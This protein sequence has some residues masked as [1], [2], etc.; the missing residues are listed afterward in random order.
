M[1][2]KLVEA[3]MNVARLNFSH[4]SHA[5]HAAV[6]R[7]VRSVSEE[8]GQPVAVMQ[9][10][11]GP[12]I[13]VG[14]FADGR[15][16]LQ[17]G[18][19]FTFTTQKVLGDATRVS[20]S[21]AG[22][23][24]DVS[25]GDRFLVD[26]GDLVFEVEST[27]ET[28]V[29]CKVI[30]GGELKNRRGLNA[31]G[32]DLQ[33]DG[34]TQ[35]DRAD[36]DFGVKHRVDMVAMSFVSRA[37]DVQKLKQLLHQL[38]ATDMPVVAK[39]ERRLAL[40]N[41]DGI[42][43]EVYAVMVARGDLALEI[44]MREIPVAQKHIIRVCRQAG[45]PVITATQMLESMIHNPEPT[46]AEATD[47]ANAV[48]DG[49]DALML[50]G[51]TAIGRYPEE[52]VRTM[53]EIAERAEHAV[54]RGEVPDWEPLQP[55]PGDIDDTIAA[56]AARAAQ[57]LATQAILAVTRSGSTALRLARQ[58]V[59]SPIVAVTPDAVVARRLLLAWGVHPVICQQAKTR[60]EQV[61]LAMRAAQSAGLVRQGDT[62]VLAAGL[63]GEAPG[64]TNLLEICR[65]E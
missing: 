51:E 21:Y 20:V 13:R 3:G 16:T 36:L 59:W 4:G 6:I 23:P 48:F 45:K 63:P 22:L 31:P 35:K 33:I 57:N 55:E 12:R 14:E 39:I 26:D 25:P 38:K 46:R 49:S 10:L 65:V 18:Q 62:V 15:V 50:S 24:A 7:A 58:R 53:V 64:H 34:I 32:V 37:E 54:E 60:D 19:K 1:L 29:H 43:G 30:V 27:T 42:L 41:L 2:R 52:T 56:L 61:H 9:D 40:E 47:V 28:E 5:E 11:Q 44:S 17:P 8:L